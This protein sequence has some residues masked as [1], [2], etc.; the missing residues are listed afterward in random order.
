MVHSTAALYVPHGTFHDLWIAVPRDFA[1]DS[2]I[3]AAAAGDTA[4]RRDVPSR[5]RNG[6]RCSSSRPRGR[7]CYGRSAAVLG[8]WS[9]A[10]TSTRTRAEPSYFLPSCVAALRDRSITQ[11]AAEV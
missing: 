6:E 7:V 8:R 1:Q 4:T 2:A 9:A 11:A 3:I 10:N 5:F